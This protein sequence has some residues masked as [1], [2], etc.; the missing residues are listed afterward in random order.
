MFFEWKNDFGEECIIVGISLVD[1]QNTSSPILLH[2]ILQSTGYVNRLF[3]IFPSERLNRI[4]WGD[5]LKSAFNRKR[6]N[7]LDKKN[8][9]F[10]EKKVKDQFSSDVEGNLHAIRNLHSEQT[11]NDAEIQHLFCKFIRLRNEMDSLAGMRARDDIQILRDEMAS[12]EEKI[13]ELQERKRYYEIQLKVCEK[14]MREYERKQRNRRIFT[15]GGMLEAFLIE[16]LMLTDNEVHDFLEKVFRMP[17][18]DRLLHKL[19]DDARTIAQEES[20]KDPENEEN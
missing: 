6:E 13:A 7:H 8:K 4:L 15:R 1:P 18:V 14:Q 12:N 19:L 10:D 17:E 11:E 16:P 5:D 20:E 2:I 9:I 3:E